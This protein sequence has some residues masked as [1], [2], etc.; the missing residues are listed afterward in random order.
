M[1][2]CLTG[3]TADVVIADDSVNEPKLDITNTGI[4]GQILSLNTDTSKF[5]WVNDTT[6]ATTAELARITANEDR[7]TETVADWVST[8]QYNNLELI[9]FTGDSIQEHRSPC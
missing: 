8:R 6:G 3:I 2:L 7:L 1:A 5:T 9:S 4:A